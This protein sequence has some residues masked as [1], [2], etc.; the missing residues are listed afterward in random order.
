MSSLALSRTETQFVNLDAF[1]F[2]KAYA[3]ATQMRG[4]VMRLFITIA[5]Y[6]NTDSGN[7]WPSNQTL[8]DEMGVTT[9]TVR[10]LKNKLRHVLNIT[11]QTTK[12]G[13][14]ST[15]LYTFNTDLKDQFAEWRKNGRFRPKVAETPSKHGG[16]NSSGGEE[17]ISPN[18]GIIN[19]Q[20]TNNAPRLCINSQKLFGLFCQNTPDIP[21]DRKFYEFGHFKLLNREKHGDDCQF[22]EARWIRYMSYYSNNYKPEKA[23]KPRSPSKKTVVQK[24]VAQSTVPAHQEYQPRNF[25]GTG[26]GKP[27]VLVNLMRD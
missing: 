2:A 7:A 8:A 3:R 22:T 12:S 19:K 4:G 13:R 9:R 6:M 16:E 15:N 11:G 20:H 24:V 27:A 17:K 18:K 21:E 10:N 23:E 25:E 26:K 14:T 5:G 1:N